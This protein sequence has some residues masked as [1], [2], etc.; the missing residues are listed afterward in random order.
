[1]IMTRRKKWLI[2][3]GLSL[4][5]LMAALFVVA[6]FLSKHFEPYIREQ[7]IEYLRRRFDSEVELAG[8]HVRMPEFSPVRLLLT[9]GRGAWARVD[10]ENLLMRHKGRRDVAA[11]FGI[12]KF[13]FQ[14]DLGSLFGPQKIVSF[15]TLDG[16]EIHVPPKGQ[17]PDLS[18]G[19][20][21]KDQLAQS[22]S[23]QSTVLIEEVIVRDATLF[24]L[25]NDKSK[26][27]LRF[28]IDRLRLE[29]AGL[30]VAMKYDATLTNPK[31]PGDI[32]SQGSFGPWSAEEPGDTPLAGTYSFRNADLGV[33]P[34]IAGVLNSTG[35]FEGTL[36]TLNVRGEAAVPD[37]RLKKSGNPVPLVTRFEV[38]V[39]GTNG[40]TILKPVHATLGTTDFTTSGGVIKH[41]N[42]PR[43][44]IGLEVS[45]PR[46]NL[47]DF[48][49][50]A[51]KGP[52]LMEGKIVLHSKI[53]I[54]P[55]SGK[56]K[57][58]LLLDGHFEVLRGKFLRSAIQDQ[59]DALSRRGQGQPKN[60][61][62]DEVISLM[63]GTFKLE[64]QVM[65][66]NPLSF[67][68]PGAA[69]DLVG[70]YDIYRDVLDFRGTMKL[71]AKVSQTMTGWKRWVLKPA[72]P[73]FAKEG[74]GT[75]LRIK[76]EGPANQPKFGL[77]RGHK[78]PQQR[79]KSSQK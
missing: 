54:P 64:D 21:S 3:V 52:P 43:R 29:S 8:L 48:L 70:S 38:L 56:V 50:L 55:L 51:M 11:M 78:E 9:R 35:T 19:D 12:R 32:Q 24:I 30:N 49:R 31:P 60:T 73:F 76:V 14:V 25:P 69:F 53:D 13:S 5:L 26:V 46:G 20:E 68:V 41:I 47:A 59:V 37:F 57:E 22:N 39:D 77:D 44:T 10:G 61:E 42:D 65:S 58:K 67:S 40:D 33:F 2:G 62:I 45:V 18:R 72:D 1:M 6:F 23:P 16:M 28:D 71:Q 4:V 15:V 79:A 7:A 63:G 27:P 17:R 34:A 75:F 74:A 66:F 36:S